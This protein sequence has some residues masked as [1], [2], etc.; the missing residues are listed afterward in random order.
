MDVYSV[1]L[2]HRHF[3]ILLNCLLPKCPTKCLLSKEIVYTD[4]GIVFF[5]R[6]LCIVYSYQDSHSMSV[7]ISEG[8]EDQY[9]VVP[10]GSGHQEV[11]VLCRILNML[12]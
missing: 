1:L 2:F 7:G 12:L 5:S 3:F 4:N 11:L 9:L 10:Q 8:H 6:D